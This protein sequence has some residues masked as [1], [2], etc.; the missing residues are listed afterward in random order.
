[1]QLA[2][3]TSAHPVTAATGNRAA[4]AFLFVCRL[5]QL[6]KQQQSAAAAPPSTE[7]NDPKHEPVH[8]SA[9]SS[10]SMSDDNLSAGVD[11]EANAYS[12]VDEDELASLIWE[13]QKLEKDEAEDDEMHL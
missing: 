13:V 4:A 5:A 11:E 7:S 10:S 12:Y 8:A 1:M 3:L 9:T 6:N 2:P